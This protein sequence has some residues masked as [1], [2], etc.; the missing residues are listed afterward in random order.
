MA[1]VTTNTP[2]ELPFPAVGAISK[3]IAFNTTDIATAQTVVVGHL[4]EG[5]FVTDVVVKVVTAFD[6]GSTNVLVVGTG[7]SNNELIDAAT[8]NK[9]IDETSATFQRSTLGSGYLV[10][11]GGEKVFVQ[12][13]QTGTAAT[14]GDAI[15]AVQ[16][17]TRIG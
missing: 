4:P 16:Y 13:T 10:G 8:A 9:S 15:V 7:S 11:A 17:L 14:A 1:V 2:R 12:Y 3:R 5:A 6:A